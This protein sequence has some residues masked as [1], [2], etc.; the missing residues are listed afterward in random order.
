MLDT[1]YLYAKDNNRIFINTCLGCN[2]GCSYCYLPKMGY[3]NEI[4]NF[5]VK[6]AVEILNDI[7]SSGYILNKDTLV[8]LGCFTECFN[9]YNKPYTIELVKYFLNMGNQVQ[10]S[11]KKEITLE[12]GK[13]FTDVIKYLGQLVIFVSSSTIRKWEKIEKNTT[14]PYDRFKTFQLFLEL[15]IPIVLYM[16]PVL[17]GITINDIDLYKNLI[18]KYHIQDVVIGSIFSEQYS[19]E[20]VHFSNKNQLF[21][22]SVPDEVIIENA[23]KD[24]CNVYKKSSQVMRKYKAR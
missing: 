7:S 2:G 10:L 4:K 6:T 14:K 9:D 13:L 20:T 17:Q 23:L 3:S 5:K 21:Y 19:D 11:T 24:I 1:G 16:K 22:N 12:E 8:T 18:N 15:N